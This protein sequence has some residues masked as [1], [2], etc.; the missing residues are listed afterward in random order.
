MPLQPAGHSLVVMHQSNSG[1]PQAERAQNGAT[2]QCTACK[3]Q[4]KWAVMREAGLPCVAAAAPPPGWLQQTV[5][6]PLEGDRPEG[7]RGAWPAGN[8]AEHQHPWRRCP[9]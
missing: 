6:I 7:E 4:G 3:R 9:A 8:P 5:H 1:G 2:A